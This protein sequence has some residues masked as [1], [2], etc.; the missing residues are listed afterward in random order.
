MGNKIGSGY[1]LHPKEPIVNYNPYTSLSFENLVND[2]QTDEINNGEE[3]NGTTLSF[4][5]LNYTIDMISNAW[6]KLPFCSAAN[7]KQILFE[8]SGIFQQGMN[9]ILGPTGCGK[10]TLLDIL[11]DRKDRQNCEGQVLINGYERPPP[12]IFRPMVGYV[13]QDD[14][15]SGT[16][17]VR[18]NIAFSANLRLH[19]SVTSKKR[20]ARV[21]EVIKQLGLSECANTRMGSELKRGVSGGERKR[22]CIAMELVLSPKI[23]FLDEPTTGLDASTACDVMICLR[24]LSRKGCTIV[25]S[26]HQPRHSIF[27]LF[28]TV[29][30]LSHGHNVYFGSPAEVRPY[31]IAKNFVCQQSENP[32]DFALD[33][34]ITAARNNRT[35]ELCQMYRDSNMHIENAEYLSNILDNSRIA[36][37]NQQKPARSIKSEFFYVSQRTLRTAIRNSALLTWQLVVAIILALLTGLLYYRLP[38]TIGSGVQNRLGGIFFVVVNQIFSTAT[39]LEPFIKERAL[40]IH[41]NVSG[42]YSM[43][44]LFLVKLVC[45]LLPMR[46]IPSIIFSIICYMMMGLKN[47]IGKFFVFFVTIFMANVFGSATCFFVAASISVFAVALIILVLIFVIMMVFSGFLVELE[48]V[49]KFLR[50]IKWFSA[51]RYAYNVLIINEFRNQ[52]F[53]GQASDFYWACQ[54]DEVDLVRRILLAI[55]FQE[56]TRLQLNRSTALH[57]ASYFGHKEIVNLLLN[58]RGVI[59]HK[60][61]RHGLTAY[62]EA[63]NDEIRQVFHR[64]N[65]N[66]FCTNNVDNDDDDTDLSGQVSEVE[67][68]R[69][70]NWIHKDEADNVEMKQTMYHM[71]IHAASVSGF[72]YE[73]KPIRPDVTVMNV[74]TVNATVNTL[75]KLLAEHAS[76]HAQYEKACE[77]VRI[78]KRTDKIEPLLH[79]SLYTRNAF[80]Q[81]T[82]QRYRL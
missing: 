34:L 29:L 82:W 35:S 58:E 57:A 38:Q 46:V 11:A 6:H 16:L 61:N 1:V 60:Q 69:F 41:E 26:I 63:A 25:F 21:E 44:T 77:V 45:D 42:Y 78:Y 7:R 65:I 49:F 62:E 56:I 51:F 52:N 59:R 2:E 74:S 80:L 10:S 50:W 36:I 9:A 79:L 48:S 54:A 24:D 70:G 43:S 76:E 27:E 67:R 66:C 23:L 3:P 31:F 33:V 64:M 73:L 5:N 39:A 8:V 4:H 13:V 47:D 12:S 53:Y 68:S 40:F 30:L 14:I 71:D 72:R 18:E 81:N 32:A 37:K 19:P 20:L 15:I 28:D 17:T 75:Q 55:P 22:T